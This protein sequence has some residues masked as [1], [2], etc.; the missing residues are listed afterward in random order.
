M[1]S[2][3]RSH[4][5]VSETSSGESRSSGSTEE[6]QRPLHAVTDSAVKLANLR[7]QKAALQ[8]EMDAIPRTTKFADM[9]RPPLLKKQIDDIQ[10]KIC[11]AT[12]ELEQ[13]AVALLQSR[14]PVGEEAVLTTQTIRDAVNEATGD[15]DESVQ[16][17]AAQPLF[18]TGPGGQPW[19]DG[20]DGKLDQ[21]SSTFKALQ[22]VQT[23]A[24][25]GADGEDPG[26]VRLRM[27]P[28]IALMNAQLGEIDGA[29]AQR[30]A[31]FAETNR[32]SLTNAAGS[33]A[34]D[35][36]AELEKN[37]PKDA[38]QQLKT[39]LA[40]L[41][42]LAQ[43]S[44]GLRNQVQL[45]PLRELLEAKHE[46]K[47]AT[48]FFNAVATSSVVGGTAAFLHALTAN[49]MGDNSGVDPLNK[50]DA[51]L[52][53][54]LASGF[55]LGAA[56]Y[57]VNKGLV[58]AVLALLS[59][60]KARNLTPAIAATGMYPEPSKFTIGTDHMPK[61]ISDQE[62][63][64]AKAKVAA[65]RRTFQENLANP[66]YAGPAGKAIGYVSYAIGNGVRAHSVH[67]AALIIRL[68]QTFLSQFAASAAM[69]SMQGRQRIDGVGSYQLNTEAGRDSLVKG[70]KALD[71]T[72]TENLRQFLHFVASG[73]AS[74][75]YAK[76]IGLANSAAPE[77]RLLNATLTAA[78]MVPLL[79]VI[80]AMT[81]QDKA[82]E[83]ARARER[84]D[85]SE[86]SKFPATMT[87]A[88]RM[89][90]RDLA[91]AERSAT[92]S[93][94]VL[95]ET[96]R[97]VRGASAFLDA[98]SELAPTAAAETIENVVEQATKMA[99]K[100]LTPALEAASLGV[101][102]VSEMARAQLPT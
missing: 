2:L 35:L 95:G 64:E 24:T 32:I 14:A 69:T 54:G 5:P 1:Q 31:S 87:V 53:G 85:V 99:G 77:S 6:M 45:E 4:S 88:S 63:Q 60:L 34:A 74:Q 78:G 56:V 49:L 48:F 27:A 75:Y 102:G 70:I 19:A 9:Q 97:V 55:G 98:A 41:S 84:G 89:A 43:K 92:G 7:K 46:D 3:E 8:A 20:P 82:A 81:E 59:Q 11:S 36:Y 50:A 16:Q 25:E 42:A 44:A 66:T 91:P 86:D 23:R 13:T 96:G 28:N 67:G 17:H 101:Q 38:S 39:T 68:V 100:V 58:P 61:E 73:I 93:R 65:Q 40:Q 26:T 71:P 37:F 57:I 10:L 90:L 76:A 79:M 47:G 12:F 30:V 72:N 29:I 80:F 94:S 51:T 21:L 15:S 62:F 18:P 52:R 83:I 33:S 22:R